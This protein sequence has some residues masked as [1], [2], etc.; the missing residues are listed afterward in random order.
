ME[1]F[2][3]PWAEDAKGIQGNVYCGIFDQARPVK[4]AQKDTLI[5]NEQ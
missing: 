4:P 1:F 3:F 5:N 2:F